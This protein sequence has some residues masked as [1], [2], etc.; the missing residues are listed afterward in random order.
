[1][2]VIVFATALPRDECVRRLLARVSP[3]SDRGDEPIVH[4]SGAVVGNIRDRRIRLLGVPAKHNQFPTLLFASLAGRDNQ[5]RLRCFIGPHPMGVGRLAAWLALE[6]YRVDCAIADPQ[7]GTMVDISWFGFGVSFLATG[8]RAVAIPLALVVLPALQYTWGR[9][10]S[11]K[12]APILCEFI[13]ATI[14][15]NAV[16]LTR[17]LAWS[18]HAEPTSR[19]PGRGPTP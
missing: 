10:A 19:G 15:A 17:G 9:F 8:W 1:M 18:S 3:D 7:A 13:R 14:E 5:T 4:E 12:D 11:R 2:K 16:P 6:L